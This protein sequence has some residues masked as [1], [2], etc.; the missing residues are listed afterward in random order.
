MGCVSQAVDLRVADSTEFA[1]I[2]RV[3]LDDGSTHEERVDVARGKNANPLSDDDRRRKFIECVGGGP[4]A[5]AVWNAGHRLG[6]DDPEVASFVDAL[7]A[8]D[9]SFDRAPIAS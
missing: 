9:E 4:A 7:R 8:L 5:D 6:T 3:E 2:V 1:A